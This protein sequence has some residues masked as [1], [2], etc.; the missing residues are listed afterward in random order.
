MSVVVVTGS[1]GLI[2]SQAVRHF[3]ALGLDVVGIDNNMRESF[4]GPDGSVN[5]NINSLRTDLGSSYTHIDE[6]IRNADRMYSLWYA[7][8]NEITLV[9]H[10]AAQPSH[11]WA[12]AD[13][14]TDFEV[15]AL[16]TFNV[17]EATRAYAPE[18]A[19]VFTS[20]NKVY[21]DRPNS[22]PL[23][24]LETRFELA[25]SHRYADGI[26]ES[27]SI[28]STMHSVFGA[29]KVAA[30]VM[31][32]E[33][34]RYYDLRTAAF[35][36]GTLTG[37]AHRGA[38]LHGFLAYLMRCVA[39]GRQYRVIG[40]QGKQVRDAI[41]A[42]DVVT[43]FEHFW[44]A[45]R[46]GAVY[47]IGGGRASNVSVIEALKIAEKIAGRRADVVHVAT[48]R[49]G[50]HIWWISNMAR[51]RSDYPGWK[52]TYDIHSILSEIYEYNHER[53]DNAG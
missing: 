12:A 44:R 1:G 13:P 33:Y 17:L 31:V 50:D 47:N 41:H 37:A 19:F 21:G 22:L 42:Q 29:S 48:P 32:Q 23:R 20:T 45:P 39:T 43:A 2:G 9:V 3:A 14:R 40:H 30:D 51:F 25:S 24:S 52:L 5:R 36:G 11:D 8:R 26:D 7:Y 16:G 28:D 15:N 53:W 35:R 6:D 49:L 38:E 27:M 18:A 10:A 34:G 4:F 46:F